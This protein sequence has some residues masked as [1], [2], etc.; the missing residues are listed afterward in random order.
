MEK[1]THYLDVRLA[2]NFHETLK[3]E[4]VDGFKM[5]LGVSSEEAIFGAY[6]K[7][8]VNEIEADIVK[9]RFDHVVLVDAELSMVDNDVDLKVE[10]GSID[11]EE[12]THDYPDE[13]PDY[14][15]YINE[16]APD[17][18]DFVYFAGNSVPNK[19]KEFDPYHYDPYNLDADDSEPKLP[20][21][22][23][24]S[25][26]MESIGTNIS[27]E[28]E[29]FWELLDEITEDLFNVKAH[30]ATDIEVFLEKG[31][32][33]KYG[34][35]IEQELSEYISVVQEINEFDYPYPDSDNNYKYIISYNDARNEIK[36]VY[37]KIEDTT[38]GE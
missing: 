33:S 36:H 27:E 4:V 7:M 11:V 1:A 37:K 32:H 30:S 15:E 13:Y 22:L 6:A 3:P 10:E 17:D 20:T 31:I 34:E 24:L 12:P 14:A 5:A 38:K 29:I 9:K 23:E 35:Q 25:D 18:V 21:P 26:I 28:K 8:I 2:V 19:A 16:L